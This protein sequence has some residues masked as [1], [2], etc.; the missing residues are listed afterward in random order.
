MLALLA[1]L[2]L[3]A[4]QLWKTYASRNATGTPAPGTETHPAV[5]LALNV[6]GAY[7]A[8]RDQALDAGLVTSTDPSVITDA[9]LIDAFEADAIHFRDHAAALLAKYSAPPTL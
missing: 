1:P 9:Q 4:I 3:Q 2:A 5:Q 8:S 7:K 6:I